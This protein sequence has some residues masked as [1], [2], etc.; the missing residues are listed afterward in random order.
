MVVDERHLAWLQHQLERARALGAV[1]R[2]LLGRQEGGV[3]LRVE[4]AQP[5]RAGQQ[6]HAAALRRRAVERE[7]DGEQRVSVEELPPILVP[8]QRRAAGRGAHRPRRLREEHRAERADRR[9]LAVHPR[10]RLAEDRLAQVRHHQRV[11]LQVLNLPVAQRRPLEPVRLLARV[12]VPTRGRVELHH[13][14]GVRHVGRAELDLVEPSLEDSELAGIEDLLRGQDHEA[15]L[16]VPRPLVG[17]DEARAASV[18]RGQRLG[19]RRRRWLGLRRCSGLGRTVLGL[20][21]CSGLG[22]TVLG[23]RRCSGLG[24]TRSLG[25][26]ATSEPVD[27]LPATVEEQCDA[28]HRER[29]REEAGLHNPRRVWTR[30][31]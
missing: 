12:L 13:H 18:W 3:V 14:P 17:A 31:G 24:R 26:T 2:G 11:A 30:R 23:L 22:R 29:G 1:P 15:E 7:V 4:H 6:A 27:D 20:R 9:R 19:R 5:V 21:R 10:A 25:S 16:V 8:R 28:E